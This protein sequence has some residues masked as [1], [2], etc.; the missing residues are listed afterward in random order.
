MSDHD[1][2]TVIV[3]GKAP[4]MP[5]HPDLAQKPDVLTALVAQIRAFRK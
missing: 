4:A 2:A 3:Q 1:I 5:Q